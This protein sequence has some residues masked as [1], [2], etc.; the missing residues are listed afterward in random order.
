M[1]G[2]CLSGSSGCYGG[3]NVR[4]LSGKSGK[5]LCMVSEADCMEPEGETG[6]NG[7]SPARSK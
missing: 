3:G 2:V 4:L 6:G 7:E 5:E 1:V